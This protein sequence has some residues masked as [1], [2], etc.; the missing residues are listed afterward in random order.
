MICL[1]SF[2]EFQILCK[3]KKILELTWDPGRKLS[4]SGRDLEFRR[5]M[6][7]SEIE[8]SWSCV[9]SLCGHWQ[10]SIMSLFP[11]CRP[12][13]VP[14]VFTMSLP[15]WHALNC[16][17]FSSLVLWNG[18]ILSLSWQFLLGLG[19]SWS[20]FMK[21]QIPQAETDCRA[22]SSVLLFS[23]HSWPFSLSSFPIPSNRIFKNNYLVVFFLAAFREKVGLI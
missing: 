9:F 21:E 6:H 22:Q 23:L 18:W 16:N 12:L 15:P 14:T 5:L 4:S 10:V 3:K 2:S 11:G 13:V 17:L 19:A 8:L 20:S 1:I 7:P